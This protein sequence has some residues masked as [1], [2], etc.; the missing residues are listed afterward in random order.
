MW[1]LSTQDEDKGK[2]ST[3]F[4]LDLLL[5]PLVTGP[6]LASTLFGSYFFYRRYLRRIPSAEFVTPA[7]LKTDNRRGR[8][9]K[10][11]VTRW[12][13]RSVLAEGRNEL[14]EER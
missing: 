5:S 11:V 4:D 8:V 13:A 1:P 7:M 6:V 3:P 10:G 12:A 9:I 14:T 2:R